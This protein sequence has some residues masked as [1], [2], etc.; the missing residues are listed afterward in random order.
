MARP[1]VEPGGLT[2]TGTQLTPTGTQPTSTGTQPTPTGTQPTPTG[3]Q[4]TPTGTQPGELAHAAHAAFRH[5]RRAYERAHV[6]SALRGV[7]LAVAF[8]LAAIALHRTTHATWLVAA[9]LAATLATL[10]WRGG[11]WRRGS[12]A[13]LLAG[14]PVF[15]APA[16]YYLL[17]HGHHCPQCAMSPTLPCLLVCLG[18]SSTVGT[19]VGYLAT[20]D[21][22]PHRFGGGALATALLAGLLGCGSVGFG[23]ALGVVIGLVAGGVTGWV[24]AG[25]TAT[26]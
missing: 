1:D 12:L 19:A 10:G 8:T 16:L 6:V 22:S 5:A 9:G 21:V 14:V 15:V 11:A 20:R 3:T 23:G 4:P 13:G 2:P 24:V 17:A 18:T 26:A 7:A 25:R